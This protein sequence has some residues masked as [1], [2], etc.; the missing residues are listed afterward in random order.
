MRGHSAPALLK[1][2]FL[3]SQRLRRQ[4]HLPALVFVS[5]KQEVAVIERRGRLFRSFFVVV[6]RT[7]GVGCQEARQDN[8]MACTTARVSG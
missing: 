4:V 5:D 1:L 6:C 7:S 8:Q 3:L 2:L